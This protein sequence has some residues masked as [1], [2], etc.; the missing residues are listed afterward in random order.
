MMLVSALCTATLLPAMVLLLKP[1]FLASGD[2]SP[3]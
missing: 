1:K 3:D 2:A